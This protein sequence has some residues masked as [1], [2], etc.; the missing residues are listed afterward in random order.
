MK[1]AMTIAGLDSGGGAGILAD[2]KWFMAFGV[3]GMSAVT[4][5][6]AQNTVCLQGGCPTYRPNS[7]GCRSEA[8]WTISAPT[9]P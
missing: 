4:A 1:K 7:Y 6:T 3:C 2:L 9:P 8:P 5:L